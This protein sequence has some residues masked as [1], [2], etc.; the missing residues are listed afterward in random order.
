MGKMK[1]LAHK[2]KKKSV[3][4]QRQREETQE[5]VVNMLK[6]LKN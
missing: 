1:K 5:L 4:R 2:Q 3:K 6:K